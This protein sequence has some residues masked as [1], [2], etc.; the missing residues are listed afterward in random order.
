MLTF[1]LKCSKRYI[2]EQNDFC[3]ISLH[4]QLANGGWHVVQASDQW[5]FFAKGS[6]SC[7]LHL[8]VSH[9]LCILKRPQTEHIRCLYSEIWFMVWFIVL[10]QVPVHQNIDLK[11][12]DNCF[13]LS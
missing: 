12:T 7:N 1:R 4:H 6:A 13:L 3:M 5:V 11:P 9:S 8:C 10:F 2:R